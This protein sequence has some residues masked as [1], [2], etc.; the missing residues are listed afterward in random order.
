MRNMII[1]RH[2]EKALTFRYG[3]HNVLLTFALKVAKDPC[4]VTVKAVMRY[5]SITGVKEK[6]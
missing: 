5:E 1:L 4:A 3:A 6:C 2:F